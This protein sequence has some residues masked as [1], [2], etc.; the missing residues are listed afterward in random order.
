MNR[1][2]IFECAQLL[3]SFGA[4]ERARFPP[5]K[6]DQDGTVKRVDA[7]MPQGF[8]AGLPIPQVRDGCAREVKS[9]LVPIEHDFDLVR[10]ED[11]SFIGK[12]MRRRDHSDLPIFPQ[13]LNQAIDQPWL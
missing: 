2:T 1:Y 10:R 6:L 12:R 8:V 5:D 4:L 13:R 7:L 3:E 11:G 9:A